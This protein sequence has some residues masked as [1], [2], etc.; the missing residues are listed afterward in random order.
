MGSVLPGKGPSYIWVARFDREDR[1]QDASR[2][3]QGFGLTSVVMPRRGENNT[4][5]FIVLTGPF[6]PARIP[7]VIDWL[8]TQ[9]FQN[10]REVKGFGAGMAGRGANANP[11]LK[12]DGG[13]E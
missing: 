10:V 2:K 8:K 1:A 4:Q 12:S 5:Y 11:Q 9:G 3:I 6:P 13:T 7:S